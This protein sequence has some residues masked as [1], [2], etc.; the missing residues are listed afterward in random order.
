MANTTDPLAGTVRGTN[1]Q[2]LVE[3]VGAD[4]PAAGSR[5]GRGANRGP[6][7]G[8]TL[9]PR[10]ADRP[11]AARP[12]TPPPRPTVAPPAPAPQIVR[13]KIYTTRYWQEQCFGLTAELVVDKGVELR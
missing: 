13:D 5:G 11:H 6:G 3:K 12:A 2:F 4:A 8:G 9:S 10:H 1:P 7:R